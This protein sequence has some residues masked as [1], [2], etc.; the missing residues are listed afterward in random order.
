MDARP[1]IG[2]SPMP[3]S[4]TPP[5]EGH[6]SFSWLGLAGATGLLLGFALLPTDNG[7]RAAGSEPLRLYGQT[8]PAS[9]DAP[10]IALGWVNQKFD[11]WFN[12]E[13]PEGEQRR[14]RYSALGVAP[15][16]ARLRQSIQNARAGIHQA[17]PRSGEPRVGLD[18]VV[19]L[20]IEPERLLGTLLALKDELDRAAF[21]A[22]LDIDREAVIPERAGRLLDVDRS[23][24]A[25]ER[26]LERGADDA[27][28]S[29][30]ARAPLRDA[31]E[32][33]NV[34]HDALLGYFE[35]PYDPGTRAD[36]STFNL[37]LAASRLDGYV[38]MPGGELDFNA[39]V[40]PRDESNGY[41]VAKVIAQG[42]QV[43]GVGG[44]TCQISGTLHAAALFAGLDVVERHPNPRPSSYIELGLDAAIAYPA[45]NLRLKNAYAFPVVLRETVTDGRLRAEVRGA[46]RPHS[47][48][49]VRKIDGAT[50]FEQVERAD[51]AL[52]RG[53]RVLAQR[54]VPGINLHRYRILR[55]GAH[56]VRQVI[57]DR[58]PSIAQVIL[59]GTGSAASKLPSGT[60]GATGRPPQESSK[61]YLVDELLIMTQSAQTDGPLDEERYVGRFGVPGWTKSIGAPAWNSAP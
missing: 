37:R 51:E 58:Y 61:E 10:D 54:G 17:A 56:A 27:P 44:G 26:A 59:V 4:P 30:V 23:S 24:I 57:V 7:A 6:R 31:S 50:P 38:L 48:S 12:L 45:I 18:L 3:S 47:I 15:D 8:L 60:E 53:V 32:L 35:T 39:V 2:R 49:L 20:R 52:Q 25:I 29:F 55:D 28:L 22:R 1:V 13:L 41:R 14:V 40:G 34:A 19:P 21:D 33:G 43:D 42:E 11:G 16:G 36:D 5:P 9:A 46:Q